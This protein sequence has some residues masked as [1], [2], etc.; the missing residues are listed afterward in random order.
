MSVAENIQLLRKRNGITQEQLADEL[1]VSR[2]AIS[3]WETGEAFPETD[4]LIALCERFGVTCDTLLRGSVAEH[5]DTDRE[6][7]IPD[8]DAEREEKRRI[9]R[10]SRMIALGVGLILLGVSGCVLLIGFG[11]LYDNKLFDALGGA[12]VL[13]FVAVSV[14]LFVY[15]GIANENDKKEHPERRGIPA[16]KAKKFLRRF[17]FV[18]AGLVAGIL[19]LV[20]MLVLCLALFADEGTKQSEFNGCVIV[21]AF[22]AGLIVC[23]G[24][25]CMLG[26]RC[27][28]YKTS[29]ET[30][31]KG[32][33]N[34]S[35][36]QRIS[37]AVGGAIMLT[38]TA[39]FLLCGFLGNLWHPAWVVFPIGGILCGIVS[40]VL[41]CFE[42]KK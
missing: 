36:L 5:T 16:E 42:K 9:D 28:G 4:K 19:L 3:K 18:M 35:S 2:Q 17:P 39:V 8:R 37:G 25:L 27:E 11:V 23:V 20:V 22:F 6:N 1:G 12:C 15:G 21:A 26:I 32:K 30:A 33:E 38:A 29:G 24:G 34:E 7:G 13:L 40:T 31:Q 41:Q 14:F 10:F